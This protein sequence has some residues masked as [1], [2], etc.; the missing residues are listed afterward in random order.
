MGEGAC[1]TIADGG[2]R[3]PESVTGQVLLNRFGTM[4]AQLHI[5]LRLTD[6]IGM[7]PRFQSASRELSV[8]A[9]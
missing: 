8:G 6:D 5:V 3:I 4:P 1:R 9:R 7:A 2:E